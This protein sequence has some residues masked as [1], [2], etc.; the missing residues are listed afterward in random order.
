MKS[1]TD[2]ITNSPE[3][4]GKRYCETFTDFDNALLWLHY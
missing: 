3:L 1:L 4:A 2:K